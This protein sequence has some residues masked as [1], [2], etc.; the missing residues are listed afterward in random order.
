MKRAI[1]SLFV[2][3]LLVGLCFGSLA[4]LAWPIMLFITAILALPLFF[5]L[6]GRG[7]LQWWHACVAGAGC[8]LAFAALYWASSPA[9]HLEVGGIQNSIFFVGLGCFVGLA[10]WGL[11][12]FRNSA[13]PHVA[14]KLPASMLLLLPL[15]ASGAYFH[16]A[17]GTR[18]GEGRVLVILEQPGTSPERSGAV[19]LRLAD[20]SIVIARWPAGRDTVSPTGVCFNLLERRSVT[21]VD[22]VYFLLSPKFGKHGDDC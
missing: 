4:I 10:F 16:H 11:G 3:P 21:L 9:Y 20:G 17:L 12:I 13:F 22:K 7:W 6:Q 8:G 14:A 18:I 19:S 2:A 1:G 5:V 15:A